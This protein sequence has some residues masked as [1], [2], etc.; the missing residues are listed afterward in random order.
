MGKVIGI[1]LGTTNSCVAVMEGSEAKVITNPE[2]G[3]TTPSIVAV[4]ESGERLVG[5]IAKR[6]AITNPENTVF[7][8]KRLIGRKY[9]SKEVQDDKKILPYKI[10]QAENG[11]VRIN[12][13]GK[14][15]SPAEISSH[16]LANIKHTAEEYLGEKITDVVITVPAYFNDSQRQAT[17]D[18]GKIAGLNV[19]RIINE[20]TAAALAYGLDKKKEEKIAV[21]DL[22]GGTFDI[23]ILEIGEGVFEVKSTNGDTHLGGED[24][25]LRLIDYFASEFKKDQGIDIRN[26]KMALQRLKEAS[27]KAKMELSTSMETDVNLPFITADASG[28]KHLNIKITRAK[29]EG[30]ISDLLDNLEKPCRTALKDAGLTPKDINEVILVGGMTRMPAVQERVKNIFGKEP[31]KGVNPDEVV[32]IGA[33]IQ[34]GVLRGDVKDVL[35]LDVTPLSL[36]IETL[37]GVMTRLIEKNTTIP[38]KKSQIFST[39]ADSQPAVS[40]HVLQGEREMAPGNKT[41]GRFELVGI[42]PAPRGVPQIEVTFDIDAN[43]I[44][45]VSAKDTATGKEQSIQITASSGLSEEEIDKLIK[46]AELHAEDDKKKRELVEARNSADALIYSTEKSIKD[47]GDKV[48]AETKSKVE[49]SIEPLKKA[50]EGEDPEEIKRLSEELTQASHK[51]AEAVYQQASQA[52]AQEQPGAEAEGQEQPGAS[53]PDE[54][55]VDADFEE[56][57]DDEKK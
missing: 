15:N 50:M 54:D 34:G 52:D 55:V 26:D 16:I 24:F 13:R 18:A 39:A 7:A 43:G 3:R 21:F 53:A 38:T 40:I 46:D 12:L 31:H 41:L 2:G 25:D 28:P 11:D 45:N 5:Q 4:S 23:S 36:G 44:V 9:A 47:L 1:D 51:L 35:L 14:S 33:G 8:V 17:K 6:Q 30:L 29:L 57:N 27:E 56:V 20:P 37:G 49:A 22:G 10:E 42:P 48:D 19:L 32:A